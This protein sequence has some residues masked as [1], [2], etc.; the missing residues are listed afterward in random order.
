MGM[1]PEILDLEI[2]QCVQVKAG[3]EMSTGG[4]GEAVDP[5]SMMRERNNEL[6]GQ[7]AESQDYL[8]KS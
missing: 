3:T 6:Q 5:Y 7:Q 2:H 4:F 1:N 8:L